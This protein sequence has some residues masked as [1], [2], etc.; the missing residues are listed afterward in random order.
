MNEEERRIETLK[1]EAAIRD[2][3]ERM[4]QACEITMQAE[5]AKNALLAAVRSIEELN[6]EF[7][8]SFESGKRTFDEESKSLIQA[9]KSLDLGAKDFQKARERLEKKTDIFE[10]RMEERSREFNELLDAKMGI[11]SQEINTISN[12]IL[13]IIDQNEASSNRILALQQIIEEL[14]WKFQDFGND[15][16]YHLDEVQEL[17]NQVIDSNKR[18]SSLELALEVKSSGLSH[19]LRSAIIGGGLGMVMVLMI[20]KFV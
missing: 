14:S 12:K 7:Q 3:A 9:Q 18:L 8:G 19:R 4:A 11:L 1:A 20:I 15:T 6:I 17:R 5:N 16:T 13:F 10:N 2:L